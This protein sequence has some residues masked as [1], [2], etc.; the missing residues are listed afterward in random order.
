VEAEKK[1]SA[2]LGR[3]WFKPRPPSAGQ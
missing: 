3:G 1:L 2:E